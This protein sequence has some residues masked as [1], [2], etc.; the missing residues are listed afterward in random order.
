MRCWIGGRGEGSVGISLWSVG[1]GIRRGGKWGWFG[2]W[3]L[4]LS[5]EI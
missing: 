4:K 2:L 1:L 5:V 3:S